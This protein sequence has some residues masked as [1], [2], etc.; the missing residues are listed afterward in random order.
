MR[1]RRQVVLGALGIAVAAAIL[2]W[3]AGRQIESPDEAQFA[4]QAPEP[5]LITAPVEN[6]AL[7]SDVVIRGDV[8]FSDATELKVDSG[9]EAGSNLVTGRVPEVGAT[10]NEGDIAVEVGGRPVFVLGGEL[11]MYRSL[12]PGLSGEDVG[13]LEEALARL[14]LDPGATD[15]VYDAATEA[16]VTR[17]Y[18]RAGYS[19]KPLTKDEQA[20]LDTA[21]TRVESA[22]DSVRSASQG[23]D[24]ATAAPESP[25]RSRS[26]RRWRRPNAR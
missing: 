18:E 23:L 1:S 11:P 17:L 21:E 9:G 20:Q 10:L 24:T 22:S 15:G 16:A 6:R 3:V 7:S 8:A 4:A 14:G 12:G 19:P 25:S 2:G 13:Q 5:S 26:V